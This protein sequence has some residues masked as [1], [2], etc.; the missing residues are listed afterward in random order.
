M[1][2]KKD[3]SPIYGLWHKPF[4]QTT[5]FYG[6]LG[7]VFVCIVCILLWLFIRRYKKRKAQ[8]TSW[9]KALFELENL[10]KIF[11]EEKISSQ[12]FYL[13]LTEIIKK[14]LFNRF[15]YDLFGYTD[16]EVI[17]F[18]EDKKFNKNLLENIAHM[19]ESMQ[20]VKFAAKSA[21]K[22]M[23]KKDLQRSFDLVKKTVPQSSK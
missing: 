19:F 18:L 21:A 11:A 4:W 6:L 15:G 23:I 2:S 8:K 13:S 9:Q 17:K 12:G 7:F 3:L 5:L 1:L 16:W 14:Y 20:V 22:E 10:Q